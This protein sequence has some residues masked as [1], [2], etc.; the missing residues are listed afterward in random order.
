MRHLHLVVKDLGFP[1]LSLGD[2]GFVQHVEHILAHLLKLRL[3]LLAVVTDGADVLVRTL[4]LLFL[5]DRRDDAPRCT[6]S[7]HNVLVRDRKQVSLINSEFTAQLEQHV[8]Y[9]VHDKYQVELLAYLCDFLKTVI[10]GQMKA[11]DDIK[12]EEC[13]P[14]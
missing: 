4:G 10:F 13:E 1:G 7:A 6:T 3:D 5:L 2:Q 11:S 12:P 8:N 9:L 14:S